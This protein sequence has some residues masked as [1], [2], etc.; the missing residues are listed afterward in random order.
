MHGHVQL[1][2]IRRLPRKGTIAQPHPCARIMGRRT[3][4]YWKPRFLAEGYAG[5]ERGGPRR[6]RRALSHLALRTAERGGRSKLLGAIDAL[7]TA[8]RRGVAANGGDP[9]HP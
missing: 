2:G 1:S 8:V 3:F 7:A 9:P 5:L 4:Y 6:T